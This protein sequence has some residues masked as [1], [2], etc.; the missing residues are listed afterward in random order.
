MGMKIFTG[1]KAL[2]TIYDQIGPK[3]MSADPGFDDEDY[4]LITT[5]GEP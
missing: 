1:L 4:R 3:E 5:A 2:D